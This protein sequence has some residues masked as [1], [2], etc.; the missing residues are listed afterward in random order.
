LAASSRALSSAKSGK[1]QEEQASNVPYYPVVSH[2]NERLPGSKSM[3]P[4]ALATNKV[5][6]GR[7]EGEKQRVP[8]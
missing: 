5:R 6:E 8:G 7:L 4:N 1:P 3:T 2:R